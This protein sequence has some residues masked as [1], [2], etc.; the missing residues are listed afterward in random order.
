M[1]ARRAASCMESA[2]IITDAG[3]A[4]PSLKLSRRRDM[5]DDWRDGQGIK[6]ARMASSSASGQ[7]GCDIAQMIR[8]DDAFLS[9]LC[10]LRFASSRRPRLRSPGEMKMPA[11]VASTY[12][13][14]RCADARR[15]MLASSSGR[16]IRVYECPPGGS[17]SPA[18]RLKTSAYR[19]RLFGR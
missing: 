11:P 2:A 12:Y 4:A 18:A 10:L 17:F 6:K 13:R 15:G 5:G 8:A 9:H 7:E 19:Q 16:R 1:A 14:A 3:R